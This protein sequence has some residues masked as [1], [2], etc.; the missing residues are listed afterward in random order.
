MKKKLLSVVL[1]T[2][3]ALSVCACG[4]EPQASVSTEETKVATS[5]VVSSEV[6]SSEVVEEA[7]YPIVDEPITIKGLVVDGNVETR[8]DRLVWNKVSEITGIILIRPIYPY[9]LDMPFLTEK[10][11][12]SFPRKA[13]IL[14]SMSALRRWS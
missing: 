11:R 9:C 5:E 3:M 6:V 8:K 7:L 4:N 14:P 12:H 10:P 2:A 1:A 13:Q